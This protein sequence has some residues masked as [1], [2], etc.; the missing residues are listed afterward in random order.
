MNDP[1]LMVQTKGRMTIVWTQDG[2]I[3][4]VV[5]RKGCS[6]R[7]DKVIGRIGVVTHHLWSQGPYIYH[8]CW[9]FKVFTFQRR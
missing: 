4:K 3:V 6:D 9:P 7:W 2:L 8:R 5:V 1:Q